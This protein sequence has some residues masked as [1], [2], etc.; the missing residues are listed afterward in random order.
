MILKHNDNVI[1]CIKT[2]YFFIHVKNENIAFPFFLLFRFFVDFRPFAALL[3][4]RVFS[5]V[6]AFLQNNFF[7]F[8]QKLGVSSFYPCEI[9][10]FP[11]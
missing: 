10:R 3:R 7:I 5:R 1:F 11:F 2:V 9:L 6:F 8:L 4:V